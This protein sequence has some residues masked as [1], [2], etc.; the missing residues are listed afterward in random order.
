MG[1][2]LDAMRQEKEE[3]DA[4]QSQ[5]RDSLFM[6]LV[7]GERNTVRILPRSMKYFTKE[8]DTG[9]AFRYFVHYKLFESKG[10]GRIVCNKTFGERCPICDFFHGLSDA[11]QKKAGR[12]SETYI[13]NVYD[14]GSSAIKVLQTGPFIYEE[15]LRHVADPDWG[16]LFGLKDGRD[17]NIDVKKQEGNKKGIFNPYEVTVRPV[18]SDIEST[19]PENWDE[20]VDKLEEYVPEKVS[21]DEMVILVNH[22]RNGTQPEPKVKSQDTDDDDTPTS[23]PSVQPALAPS[24]APVSPTPAV[25]QTPAPAPAPAAPAAPTAPAAAPQTATVPQTTGDRPACF[26]AEYKPRDPKCKA[27]AVRAECKQEVL[28]G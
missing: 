25:S 5:F 20:I 17:I 28:K 23:A 4:R 18:Q 8:G 6:K 21:D 3:L 14:Y 13:Y 10:Y 27:C 16:D 15:I 24:V 11:N 7:A 9:F 26:G 1:L 22:L 19:L 2:N 12:P